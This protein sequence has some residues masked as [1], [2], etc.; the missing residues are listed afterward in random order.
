MTQQIRLRRDTATTW[1]TTVPS[2]I[3]GPCEIA[4]ESD[5][6]GATTANTPATLVNGAVRFKI[7]DAVTS[8]SALPYSTVIADGNYAGTAG[9]ATAP[10]VVSFGTGVPDNTKGNTGDI[11][12]NA[13][14]GSGGQSTIYQKRGSAWAPVV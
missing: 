14:G 5:K 13:N 6:L 3:L 2:P 4:F 7:G 9:N 1:N 12:L 11:F 10:G 8:W